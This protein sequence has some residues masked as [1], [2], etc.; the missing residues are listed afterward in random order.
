MI[1]SMHIIDGSFTKLFS[2]KDALFLATFWQ[3]PTSW[4]NL[5]L[6]MDSRQLN[7]RVKSDTS[8]EGQSVIAIELLASFSSI[9]SPQ[10]CPV[11]LFG[12]LVAA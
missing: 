6:G 11:H 8:R 2:D 4:K 9:P 1:H 7:Q 10:L 3:L 12:S 5:W